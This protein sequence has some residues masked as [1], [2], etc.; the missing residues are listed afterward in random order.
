VGEAN[1]RAKVAL[2]VVAGLLP[3]ALHAVEPAGRVSVF[4]SEGLVEPFAVAFDGSGTA[5]VAEMAGRILAV[6]SKG[7]L[8]LLAGKLDKGLSGDDGPGTSALLNGPHHLLVGPDGLLYVADTFNN[9]VRRI[10]PKTGVITRFA[11]TG[12]KGFGG[13]GGPAREARFSGVFSIAFRG[14]GLYVCDLG[15]RRVRAVDLATGRISTVAGNG[16][17]GVPRDGEPALS[18][19]LVDPRA[20]AF[21]SKGQLYICERG[22]HALRVV[23]A[24]G[25][26]RTV[27]GT[28]EKGFSGDGGPA[29]EARFD[30]PKHIFVEADDSVL[31]TDT[32]N[33]VVRRYSPRDGTVTRVVGSGRKGSGGLG[34]PAGECELD[35]P[36]GAEIDPKTGAI[37]VSDSGN[38]RILRVGRPARP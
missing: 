37:F 33:H 6:D 20:I 17:T 22:G 30:G 4:V 14:N 35:R 15:N 18:Q 31:V 10:D 19:P 34:G 8:R 16:D 2:A 5:Y 28:G 36:H 25:K 32:E 27:A 24:A 1:R 38:N 11:G 13:D 21:D 7:A 3:A 9:C 26:I 23:D 12:E 29:L